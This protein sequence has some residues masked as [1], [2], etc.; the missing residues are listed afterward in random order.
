MMGFTGRLR[1]SNPSGALNHRVPTGNVSPQR[2]PEW[3]AC[4][5]GSANH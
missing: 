2:I 1:S 5:S 3:L 4:V